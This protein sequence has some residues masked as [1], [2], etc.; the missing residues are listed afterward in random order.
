M[1]PI[2]LVMAITITM[3]TTDT[4]KKTTSTLKRLAKVTDMS[5]IYFRVDTFGRGITV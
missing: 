2:V 3:Q 4:I 1:T 5:G